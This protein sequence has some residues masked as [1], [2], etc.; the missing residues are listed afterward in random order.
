MVEMLPHRWLHVAKNT[1]PGEK[2]APASLQL[3]VEEK[4]REEERRGG[5]GSSTLRCILRGKKHNGLM[6]SLLFLFRTIW[7]VHDSVR[8]ST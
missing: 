8:V 5:V 6:T 1:F 2:A 7:D 4:R 3:P